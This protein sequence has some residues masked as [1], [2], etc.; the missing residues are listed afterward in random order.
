MVER[1]VGIIDMDGFVVRK[2]F[3]C[4]ELGIWRFGDVY[5]SSYFFDIGLNWF[6]LLEKEKRHC[7]YVMKNVHRLPF[8]VPKGV[9]ARMLLELPEIVSE[10]YMQ[11]KGLKK[12]A[13]IAY[14]GGH[15]ERDL[16]KELL[17]PCVDLECYGCPKAELLFD[18]LGWLE[19]CGNHIEGNWAYKHCSKVETE[20]YGNWL[21]RTYVSRMSVI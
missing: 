12:N 18:D 7:W 9:T 2:R 19:T 3:L 4:K 11:N 20:A 8:S 17:I 14:K 13:V 1:V 10:F 15:F 21:L 6:E 5:A 16:L